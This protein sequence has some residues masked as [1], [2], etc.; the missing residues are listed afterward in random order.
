MKCCI[1]K[2][3]IEKE[4]T[5]KGKMFWS[6]GNNAQP[7]KNGRCCNECN[8][9]KVIPARLKNINEVNKNEN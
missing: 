6:K 7:L 4:Y 1:C 5:P 3:E 8:A 2:K 9:T